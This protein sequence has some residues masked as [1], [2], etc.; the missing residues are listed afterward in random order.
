MKT[1]LA[2][3][4][5]LLLAAGAQASPFGAFYD[6][7][8][9]A[10]LKPFALDLGGIIGGADFHSGRTLGFPGFDVG[11]T[12]T[13]QTR[14]NKDDIIL[15]NSG[16]HAF[17]LPMIYASVGLPF[18]IDVIG[19]GMGYQGA[20]LLGGGLRFGLWKSS[21]LSPLPDISISA[22]GDRLHHTYFSATHWSGD[23]VASFGLPIVKPYIGAGLDY[24]EVKAGAAVLPG[25][26]GA[27][28]SA[29]GT[30]FTGGVDFSPIPLM[31]LFGA[32]SLLHGIS[33]FEA[34]LGLRY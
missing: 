9:Q 27:K 33:G 32:Y 12:G 15:R 26:A 1:L 14:P 8:T 29:R 20:N 6:Q 2:L 11:V 3:V 16:V 5:M 23:V 31:H 34:G 30:R 10:A 7:A 13:L 19:R 25:V 4:S 21:K 22:F 18:N 28:A 17:G 24:T